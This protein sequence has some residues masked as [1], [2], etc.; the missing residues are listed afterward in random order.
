MINGQ[1]LYKTVF[2]SKNIEKMQRIFE[3]KSFQLNRKK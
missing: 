1:K 2:Q 3:K